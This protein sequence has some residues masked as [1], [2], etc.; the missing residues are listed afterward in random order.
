[1]DDVLGRRADAAAHAGEIVDLR[2]GLAVAFGDKRAFPRLREQVRDGGLAVERREAALM[3]LVQGEDPELGALV[4]A[5]LD[6]PAMRLAA[7]KA[8]PRALK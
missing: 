5:L 1:M 3:V 7:L 4:G 2:S 6:D 8:L